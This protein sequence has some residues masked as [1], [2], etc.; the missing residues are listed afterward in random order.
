MVY[1]FLSIYSLSFCYIKIKKWTGREKRCT[2]R[3]RVQVVEILTRKPQ[4]GA[5]L[6]YKPIFK[7]SSVKSENVIKSATYTHLF[8]FVE[9]EE[10]WIYVNPMDIQDFMYE[11]PYKNILLF[12]DGLSCIMPLLAMLIY[13]LLTISR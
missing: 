11:P 3:I 5:G 10:I 2:L 7:I 12:V 6:L 13:F 1:I 4:R 8:K 9:G